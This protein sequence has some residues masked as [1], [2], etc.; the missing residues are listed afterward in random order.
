L[1]RAGERDD[2]LVNPVNVPHMCG[3]FTLALVREFT[4][5]TAGTAEGFDPKYCGSQHRDAI[6]PYLTIGQSLDLVLLKPFFQPCGLVL[7]KLLLL[8]FT[9]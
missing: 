7:C 2:I 3:D 6:F 9:K 5:G 4:I 8:N 1:N